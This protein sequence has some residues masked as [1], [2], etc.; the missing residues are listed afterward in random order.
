MTGCPF[1]H[2]TADAPRTEPFAA[3]SAETVTPHAP[4]CKTS[5]LAA[6]GTP[7]LVL[8]QTPLQRVCPLGQVASA[9][10]VPAALQPEVHVVVNPAVHWPFAHVLA[11]VATPFTQRA[12]WQGVS[13]GAYVHEAAPAF[14]VH[15][16][17]AAKVRRVFA[18]TQTGA[19]GVVQ[20]TPAQGSPAQT[21]P[22]HPF[23]H[24]EVT[25][26]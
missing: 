4:Q 1:T 6:L 14:A 3:P 19:L 22:A 24:A 23:E 18:F 5:V 7:T 2:P 10:A 21:F 15:V 17:V 26:G 12:A 16:P 13:V 25:P 8:T 20:L 11:A 9:H